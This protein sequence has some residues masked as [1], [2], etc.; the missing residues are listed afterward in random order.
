MKETEGRISESRSR[1]RIEVGKVGR[2]RAGL[3]IG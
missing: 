1:V 2:R 3:G